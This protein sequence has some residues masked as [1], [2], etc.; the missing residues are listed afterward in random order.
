MWVVSKGLHIG[1]ISNQSIA[2]HLDLVS[3]LTL[4]AKMKLLLLGLFSRGNQEIVRPSYVTLGLNYLTLSRSAGTF[5]VGRASHSFGSPGG[6]NL[7]GVLY[8]LDEPS[9]VFTREG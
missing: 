4:S 5:Q 6:S 1:E 8:I 2:D 3:Q 7:S 9:S